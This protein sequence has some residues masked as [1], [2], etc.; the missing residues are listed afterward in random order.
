MREQHV[1]ILEQLLT[2][3][4]TKQQVW[5]EAQWVFGILKEQASDVATIMNY[6][7]SDKDSSVV[8][9]YTEKGEHEFRLQFS[10]DVLVFH[11]HTNAYALPEQHE[12]RKSSYL[13]EDPMRAYFGIINVYNFLNDSLRY[14]RQGDIG[15]LIGR[16]YI[17]KDRHFFVDG[18]RQLAFLYRDLAHQVIRE[19]NYDDYY[20]LRKV[21]ETAM[22]YALAFDLQLPSMQE[23]RELTVFQMENI[24]NELRV[25]KPAAV[26]FKTKSML[27]RKVL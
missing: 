11:L 17:N 21:V 20:M 4:S 16:I 25:R 2:K 24:S 12:L 5:R 14:N 15:Q 7:V 9:R 26:G 27:N 18:Q 23:S 3:S 8:V 19:E 22:E 10:G 13:R 6:K 1:R